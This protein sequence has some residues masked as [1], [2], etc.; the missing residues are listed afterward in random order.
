[1]TKRF[2]DVKIFIGPMSK[3]IVDSVIEFAKISNTRL[4]LI[5]S[6][7]QVEYSRGYVN[8]WT[9]EEFIHY[10]KSSTDQVVLQRDHAGRGQGDLN[11]DDYFSLA[12][13]AYHGFDL[14]HIDPWKKF[15]SLDEV[16][17]ETADN[18]RF[19]N[20]INKECH[21]EVGTEEA[22]HRYTHEELDYFLT[23]LK[24]E[25]GDL[26]EKVAYAVIQAGTRIIGTENVGVFD[27]DR[28][29]KMVKV[30]RKHQ[31]LSKEHNGDYLTPEDIQLRFSTGLD[32]LN[33]APEF[34][35]LESKTILDNIISD[36]LYEK[37]FEVCY[38]SRR[39]VKWLPKEFQ[40]SSLSPEQKRRIVEVSGHYVFAKPEFMQLKHK[41]ANVDIEIK[42]QINSL[43]KEKVLNENI[44]K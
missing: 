6:R 24:T 10:V 4:G 35:V 23:S 7:R 18:I 1:M 31:L 14:I 21:Y 39:W 41:I 16:V 17:K 22:I 5:P 40:S 2:D 32:G 29:K 11:R 36:K 42:K 33:I 12:N 25:L 38:N 19:C 26:W 34:G 13:D 37:F 27:Q 44:H 20:T 3:N 30:C 43:I 8:D 28:C 9:T 15:T